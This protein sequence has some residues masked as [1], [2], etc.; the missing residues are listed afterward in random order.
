LPEPSS[1]EDRQEIAAKGARR[2]DRFEQ[3]LAKQLA[4]PN[5]LYARLHT[6]YYGSQEEKKRSA[7]DQ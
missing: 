7:D 6:A 3:W 5:N 1:E 4:E 2:F